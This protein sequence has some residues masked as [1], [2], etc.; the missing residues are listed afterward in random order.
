LVAFGDIFESCFLA[1]QRR[2]DLRLPDIPAP[3]RVAAFSQMKLVI[4]L[5]L[6]LAWDV[7]WSQISTPLPEDSTQSA[8]E[9]V[10][11]DFEA[12]KNDEALVKLEAL[13]KQDPENPLILNL[14]GS[15]YSKKQDYLAAEAYFRKSLKK[16]P[17]FFP[18]VFNLGEILFLQK[19]YAEARAH[20]QEMRA[21]DT[22]NELLQFKVALCDLELNEND[23]ALKVMNAIKYPGDSPAWYYAQAAR[24]AKAGNKKKAR[25]YIAGAKYIFGPKTA[26]F[27]ESLETMGLNLN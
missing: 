8:I 9:L 13:Q 3:F 7:S 11:A 14:I 6:L 23:R 24:E 15:A 21:S 1:M 5:S 10:L 25:E 27:D 4:L 18:A 20:F 17:G 19:K 12:K 2:E 26:L 22:R 16:Q